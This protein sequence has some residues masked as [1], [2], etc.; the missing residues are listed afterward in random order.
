MNELDYIFY[1]NVLKL[2]LVFIGNISVWGSKIYIVYY[3]CIRKW[4]LM[5]RDGN[6]K[7][8]YSL[9]VLERR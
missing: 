8:V 4:S 1:F 2:N 6:D 3:K 5:K 9:D 7:Y